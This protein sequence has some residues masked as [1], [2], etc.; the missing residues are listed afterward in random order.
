MPKKYTRKQIVDKII[1]QRKGRKQHNT[2]Y[3]KINSVGGAEPDNFFKGKTFTIDEFIDKA[4]LTFTNDKDGKTFLDREDYLEELKEKTTSVSRRSDPATVEDYQRMLK[5]SQIFESDETFFQCVRS[6]IQMEMFI[7][8]DYDEFMKLKIITDKTLTIIAKKNG[9]DDKSISDGIYGNRA[10]TSLGSFLS[11]IKLISRKTLVHWINTNMNSRTRLSNRVQIANIIRR[12][13]PDYYLYVMFAREPVRSM[14]SN[15]FSKNKNPQ[16]KYL[17]SQNNRKYI[18]EIMSEYTKIATPDDMYRVLFDFNSYAQINYNSNT[19]SL[20]I[21][22]SILADYE[23]AKYSP[24]TTNKWDIRIDKS[25]KNMNFYSGEMSEV[26]NSAYDSAIGKR[27]PRT[28]Y[29]PSGSLMSTSALFELQKNFRGEV[30]SRGGFEI[31]ILKGNAETPEYTNSGKDQEVIFRH[32][33]I[34]PVAPETLKVFIPNDSPY[35]GLSRDFTLDLFEE[36][37]LDTEN[38]KK[39]TNNVG[40]LIYKYFLYHIASHMKKGGTSLT[41]QQQLG[42]DKIIEETAVLDQLNKDNTLGELN[43]PNDPEPIIFDDETKNKPKKSVRFQDQ[44]F[45]HYEW[46]SIYARIKEWID[47]GLSLEDAIG[48]EDEI[49]QKKLD[50]VY[51]YKYSLLPIV[52]DETQRD[53]EMRKKDQSYFDTYGDFFK[54]YAVMHAK[55]TN[56]S[57]VEAK[58]IFS[59]TNIQENVMFLPQGSTGIE[60]D[61]INVYRSGMAS[62][63]SGIFYR[64]ISVYDIERVEFNEISNDETPIYMFIPEVE[65]KELENNK[66]NAPVVIPHIV[67]TSPTNPVEKGGAEKFSKELADLPENNEPNPF[68]HEYTKENY[69]DLIEMFRSNN[70]HIFSGFEYDPNGG[71]ALSTYLDTIE[72][73]KRDAFFAYKTYEEGKIKYTAFDG[74]TGPTDSVSSNTN[75]E[76]LYGTG[77]NSFEDRITDTQIDE[78]VKFIDEQT[79]GLLSSQTMASYT[80]V[81]RENIKLKKKLTMAN[82]EKGYIYTFTVDEFILGN[83]SYQTTRE[84]I[85]SKMT[86]G[87]FCN[88]EK[89]NNVYDLDNNSVE[90]KNIILWNNPSLAMKQQIMIGAPR[91]YNGFFKNIWNSLDGKE[92]PPAAVAVAVAVPIEEEGVGVPPEEKIVSVPV[93]PL[94]PQGESEPVVSNEDKEETKELSK[95]KTKLGPNAPVP[96]SISITVTT[97]IPGHQEFKLEP[98]LFGIDIVKRKRG[99]RRADRKTAMLNPQLKLSQ[100]AIDIAD[101]NKKKQF[102]DRELF[103]TLNNRIASEHMFGLTPIPIDVAISKGIVDYNID[104]TV[105]NL[106]AP[107]TII[108]LGGEPYVIYNAEYDDSSWKL[109]PKD[110]VDMR[111]SMKDVADASVISMQARS[112]AKELQILPDEL[113]RGENNDEPIPLKQRNPEDV[114][115]EKEEEKKKEE[116]TVT[117]TIVNINGTVVKKEEKEVVKTPPKALPAPAPSTELIVKPQP[118]VVPPRIKKEVPELPAPPQPKSLPG[119]SST[120]I[121]EVNTNFQQPAAIVGDI[122]NNMRKF[123]ID[124]FFN[125]YYQQNK[126]GKFTTDITKTISLGNKVT[127]EQKTDAQKS[128]KNICK[129]I[130]KMNDTV[131]GT[132]SSGGKSLYRNGLYNDVFTLGTNMGNGPLRGKG[133][134]FSADKYN[135]YVKDLQVLWISADGNCFYSCVS[136]AFNM[137]NAYLLIG[138]QDKGKDVKDK[139]I[140]FDFID[141]ETQSTV[142]RT[143]TEFTPMFIR[144][145]VM[146]YYRGNR[147]KLLSEML[148]SSNMIFGY[149]YTNEWVNEHH[150]ELLQKSKVIQDVM[151]LLREIDEIAG[152][153]DAT[154]N[155]SDTYLHE[156]QQIMQNNSLTEEERHIMAYNVAESLFKQHSYEIKFMNFNRNF[157]I[158]KPVDKIFPFSSPVDFKEAENII[159]DSSYYA[160]VTDMEIIQEVF[161]LKVV[162]LKQEIETEV[163]DNQRSKI[164]KRN[165]GFRIANDIKNDEDRETPIDYKHVISVSYENESHYNLVVFNAFLPKEKQDAQENYKKRR[166]ISKRISKSGGGKNTRKKRGGADQRYSEITKTNYKKAIFPIKRDGITQDFLPVLE[167]KLQEQQITGGITSDASIQVPRFDDI[168]NSMPF[169]MYLLM[170][171]SYN[172]INDRMGDRMFKLFKPFYAEF[173]VIDQIISD[174]IVKKSEKDLFSEIYNRAFKLQLNDSYLIQSGKVEELSDTESQGSVDTDD[175]LGGF[176]RNVPYQP[177]PITKEVI[178]ILNDDQSNLTFH[179]NVHLTLRPGIEIK[180]TDIP[181]LSCETKLQAIKMNWA[182]ILGR[183][184]FPTPRNEERFKRDLE[185]ETKPEDKK[186][187]D[188]K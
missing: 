93:E 24:F 65:P 164:R 149:K 83:K 136:T 64:F 133:R 85:M 88:F 125:D 98:S 174:V 47:N 12:L 156:A 80:N 181:G 148:F 165:I 42:G 1:K 122:P 109:Q 185:K 184:Y 179:L 169:Y 110:V 170:Y 89:I 91:M 116:E 121:P 114:K 34:D 75:Y 61:Q 100:K 103:R 123:F 5:V 113:K 50:E 21:A 162:S 120:P 131:T 26:T 175:M 15:P 99:E 168:E 138:S 56:P 96:R 63:T 18:Y 46:L 135:E 107:N 14:L 8:D 44:P 171:T 27:I 94:P 161:K 188:D 90:R 115:N 28:K 10:E 140:S 111:L 167:K 108:Y 13:K 77:I 101:E 19:T 173:S 11:F 16:Y 117:P 9:I 92:D 79:H 132:S 41:Q 22:I 95:E 104:L 182:K 60:T 143:N 43:K 142:T 84:G 81:I 186:D 25:S 71:D 152:Q 74:I 45:L 160:Q 73:S 112:G 155:I 38:P 178:D 70:F 55:A 187:S 105:K 163:L 106:L 176:S 146:N 157:P 177:A 147:E 128:K 7:Q 180:K 86:V 151:N 36:P 97:T 150:S 118:I 37:V 159:M 4:C 145:T 66:Y 62:T 69:N 58:D 20:K 29:T 141:N 30:I 49:I 39:N 33:K 59:M 72:P 154:K 32:Q 54:A 158:D 3:K 119:I 126:D 183:P 129:M 134:V 17:I 52:T 57:I 2:T 48:K 6:F 53:E 51:N 127:E 130:S 102:Y 35:K 68:I 124:G 166:T 67:T 40:V 137:E 172:Q 153:N 139:I 23:G 82:P 76:L 31:I 78:I 87:F 144:W